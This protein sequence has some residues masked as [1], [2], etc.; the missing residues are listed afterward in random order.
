VS[1]AQTP[2]EL[3]KRR[4]KAAAD[5]LDEIQDAQ[6]VSIAIS[7][8]KNAVLIETLDSWVRAVP[9]PQDSLPESAGSECYRLCALL[10]G[11]RQV[12]LD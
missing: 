4:A 1:F 7:F 3:K 8:T 5:N 10:Q 6:Y 11:E 9:K 12:H 2:P